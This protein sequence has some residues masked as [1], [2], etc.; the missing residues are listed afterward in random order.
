MAWVDEATEL[1][2]GGVDGATELVVG[3]GVDGTWTEVDVG[4]GA[5]G[6]E[7]VLFENVLDVVDWSP[8]SEDVVD[9]MTWEEV[10]TTIGVLEADTTSTVPAWSLV[11]VARVV[12]YGTL[13]EVM[14][15]NTVDA[16][17]TPYTTV[18]LLS[19]EAWTVLVKGVAPASSHVVV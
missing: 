15:V 18:P 7:I 8:G 5:S 13:P 1:V 12:V 4:D 10:L 11:P 17:G 6:V 14:V 19:P 16:D 3:G 9:V 2:G